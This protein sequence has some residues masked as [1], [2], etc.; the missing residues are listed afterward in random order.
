MQEVWIRDAYIKLGQAMKLGGLVGSGVDAKMVIQ[1]GLVEVN[2]SVCTQRGK[3]VYHDDVVSY[4]G[5]EIRIKSE[6]S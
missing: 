1:D 3:K 5:E 6:Q 4:G 2:G